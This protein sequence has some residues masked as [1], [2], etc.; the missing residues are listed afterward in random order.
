MIPRDAPVAVLNNFNTC[1]HT[2]NRIA[3]S[4]AVPS[5][6]TMIQ[7]RMPLPIGL[8]IWHEAQ[9]SASHAQRISVVRYELVQVAKELSQVVKSKRF[10]LSRAASTEA[11]SSLRPSIT[12]GGVQDNKA[13]NTARD[14]VINFL[15]AEGFDTREIES[16]DLP[17]SVAIVKE[18]LDFLSKL[19]LEKEHINEYPL[20]IC[21][22][23]KKN[24]VPVIDY[25][26]KLGFTSEILPIFLRKYPMVLHTSVVVDLQPVVSYLEGFGIDRNDISK[27]LLKNP[28]VLGFRLEGTMS[29]S[30]AYLVS[31]G[32]GIREVAPMLIEFPQILGMRVGNNIKPKVEF[33][34]SLGLPKEAVAKI[35]EKHPYLLGLG[36]DDKIRPAIA[37]LTRAGVREQ[38]LPAVI[39]QFPDIFAL[40]V[41]QKLAGKSI[42]LTK[43]LHVEP[44][45]VARIVE[46]LPQIILINEGMAMERVNF[47]IKIGGLNENEIA[48]M[49]TRCPQILALSIEDALSPSLKF[50]KE[51]MKRP[52][53]DL[54]DFPA[55]FTYN[56]ENRIQ[57]RYKQIRQKGI[58][59]SLSWL[60]NCSDA[61]FQER[62]DLS[63]IENPLVERAELSF[64][65]ENPFQNKDQSLQDQGEKPKAKVDADKFLASE[66]D[67]N[68][69]DADDEDERATEGEEWSESD[70]AGEACGQTLMNQVKNSRR[71]I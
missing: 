13:Q 31:I 12:W 32:V 2:Q 49:V 42:W 64:V 10:T 63:Y 37:T 47:L 57:P 48:K 33:I 5:H 68:E 15:K 20:M 22:S 66:E 59:C 35:L 18:R 8:S 26:E 16:L 36:L 19:G 44:E 30:V 60:L 38:A 6:M 55:Y 50:F 21:C 58:K 34:S 52:L 65:L 4:V 61:K 51:E 67:G 23:V 24:M 43:Q 41:E 46:K 39:T 3:R 11:S 7:L 69:R 9:P 54:I 53:Q 25:L 45:D 71:V 56:L 70:E 14:E 1:L 27:V 28:D 40:N 29:T 17:T 62:L